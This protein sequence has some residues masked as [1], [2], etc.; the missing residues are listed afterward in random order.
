VR[1]S[2]RRIWIAMASACPAAEPWAIDVHR[3]TEAPRARAS[4][5]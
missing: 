4:P 2:V 1:I 5:A 3:L